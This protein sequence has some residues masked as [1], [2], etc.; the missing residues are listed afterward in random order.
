L[1]RVSEITGQPIDFVEGDLLNSEDLTAIFSTNSY[2][3]VVHFAGLKAVGESVDNPLL[4]Y[5]NNVTGTLNLLQA[6]QTARVKTIVFSSSATVY[7]DPEVLPITESSRFNP[8]NPYGH[9]KAMIEQVLADLSVS[10]PAWRIA[11]LRY[12][13]PVGAHPSGL[14]GEDPLGTPNNLMPFISQVAT[15]RRERLFVFGGDY[16]TPDGTGIRDYIHVMD[17]AQGHLAALDYLSA[18]NG[19]NLLTVNLGTGCGVSV[20]ELVES[21]Q[22]ASGKPIPYDI[23]GRRPGDVAS[24]YADP[25]L[26]S[27]LLGWK[28]E[29]DVEA[30]CANTWHWQSNNPRGYGAEDHPAASENVNTHTL[31]PS[32]APL[33]SSVDK[34]T[35]V[36]E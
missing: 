24:C 17:L 30:M 19:G 9:T 7:G 6:M 21:F 3:A 33:G 35:E 28:A 1:A 25:T 29:L 11:T 31:R 8:T 27:E 4:Y 23:V 2:D 18:H 5:Q 10:D 20:L 15:G 12:F 22:K 26:A 34:F 32:A 14:I 13:N 16:N 36:S